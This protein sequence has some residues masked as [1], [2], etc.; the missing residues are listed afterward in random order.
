MKHREQGKVGSARVR[1]KALQKRLP[2]GEVGI[3]LV[4]RKFLR[5]EQQPDGNPTY[6][7]N[8]QNMVTSFILPKRYGNLGYLAHN[9][10]AGEFF[11]SVEVGDEVVVMPEHGDILR[12]RITQKL[13]YRALDPRNPRSNFISLRDNRRCSAGDV[14]REIYMG[15]THVVLQTCIAKDGLPEWGRLFVI[16]EPVE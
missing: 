5:I 8:R 7:S 12:Y 6:V 10:L 11:S 15:A 1:I 14:F 13:E 2:E 4:G 3:Y 9:H 16:G